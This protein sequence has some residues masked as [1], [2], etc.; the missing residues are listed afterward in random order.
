[1]KSFNPIMAYPQNVKAVWGPTGKLLIAFP[2]WC[3]NSQHAEL[4]YTGTAHM[5]MT[6][7]TV[8]CLTDTNA[9]YDFI[10]GVLFNMFVSSNDSA[11]N[12]DGS[13]RGAH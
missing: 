1:M 10:A 8:I 11:C 4:A 2:N 13:L 5:L 12:K 3:P 9:T 6:I 7:L